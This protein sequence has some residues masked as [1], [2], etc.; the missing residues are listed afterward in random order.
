MKK[1]IFNLEFQNADTSSKIVA[2]LER[3]SKAFQVLLWE[4]A[5]T[6]GLSP[7]QIQILIFTAYHDESLCNVSH[8]A[9]EFNLTKPTISDAVKVLYKKGLIAKITSPLDKRAYSI[10]LSKEGNAVVKK[11]HHFAQPIF[12]LTNQIGKSEQEQFFKIFKVK[13]FSV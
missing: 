9:Q 12:N 11:T 4:H 13:S 5:K 6:I 3:L 2:G 8:L 1:S 10:T 7:I